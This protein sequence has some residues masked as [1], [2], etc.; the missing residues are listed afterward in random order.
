M[1]AA[2]AAAAAATAAAGDKISTKM[3]TTKRLSTLIVARNRS[4]KI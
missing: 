1:R 2:A 3:S 4:S